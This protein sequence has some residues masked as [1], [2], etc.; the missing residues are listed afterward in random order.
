MGKP[1]K[2]SS[3]SKKSK[4]VKSEEPVLE[5]TKKS[6][7]K[8]K[9]T[10]KEKKI[11]IEDDGKFNVLVMHLNV[12][13]LPGRAKKSTKFQVLIIYDIETNHVRRFIFVWNLRVHDIC[14]RSVS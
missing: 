4:K 6:K 1:K 5:K 7:K 14:L 10:K 2:S 11:V 8:T 3:R 12:V 9:K 13:I